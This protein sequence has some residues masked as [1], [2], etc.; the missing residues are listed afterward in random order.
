MGGQRG[1]QPGGRKGRTGSPRGLARFSLSRLALVWLVGVLVLVLVL[2]SALVLVDENRFLTRELEGR[3]RALAHLLAVAAA[4]DGNAS[5]VPLGGVPELRWARIVGPDGAVI[6]QFG[7]PDAVG[8]GTDLLRVEEV[9]GPREGGEITVTAAAST[10]RIRVHVLRSGLRLV[11]GLAA[12]LAVALL[13]GAMIFERVATPLKELAGKMTVFHPGDPA[14]G[15]EGPRGTREVEELT[16]AFQDMA[17]RLALQ[18]RSLVESERRFRELFESSPSPLLL[19][20]PDRILRRANPA[21]APYL[22]LDG[23]EPPRLDELVGTDGDRRGDGL[24][25]PE[26]AGGEAILER[27][28]RLPGGGSARVE[29]RVRRIDGEDGPH[30]LVALHD[31]TDRLRALEHRWQR[32]FDEMQDGVALVQADG[33]VTQSNRAMAPHLRALTGELRRRVLRDGRQEWELR[34]DGR[35]LLCTLTATASGDHRILVV[36]DVTDELEAEERLRQAQKMEAV[37]TLAGGVAHDFNNLLTGVLLHVRLLEHGRGDA[38]TVAAIRRLAEEGIE[39]VGEL[40]LFSRRESAP[41]QR[42][43][44]AGLVRSLEPLLGN[45]V[46]EGIELEV[47]TPAEEV[48]VEASRVGLRR[49]LFNL[50]LNARDAVESPGGRIAVAVERRGDGAVLRVQDNGSGIPSDVRQRLFEPFWSQRREGRGA[51]LGL[52]VVYAVVQQH[53]GEVL[54]DSAPGQ[55]TCMTLL[56]PL[57]PPPGEDEEPEHPVEPG[58][59]AIGRLLLVDTDGRGVSSVAELLSGR[60]AE[61]RHAATPEQV[62]R[63]VREWG[64]EGVVLVQRPGTGRELVEAVAEYPLPVALVVAEAVSP[65]HLGLS[66]MRERAEAVGATLTVKSEI[67]RG[68]EVVVEWTM[69]DGR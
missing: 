4:E 12:A 21:A 60:V 48:P 5:R 58:E 53:G 32:T 59:G 61:L 63:A 38:E 19:F 31:L 62:E 39:V 33:T 24:L 68:T 67:G 34:S 25:L 50:V 65:E 45:L 22:S 9:I 20:G 49:A 57:A 7:T 43:D 56:F 18:R 47:E 51:G 26:G 37:A 54:V 35:T 64:P 16:S 69:D 46:P 66:I 10:S 55:G 30:F 42:V 6:W 28:W 36:R 27:T 8:P 14:P 41:S 3:T 1:E 2:T 13:V 29:L 52:A 44:L 17:Q 40:L 15:L 23:D 11:L